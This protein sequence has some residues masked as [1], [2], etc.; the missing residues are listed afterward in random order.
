MNCVNQ[1]T[2]A[3]LRLSFSYEILMSLEIQG[4]EKLTKSFIDLAPEDRFVIK[5]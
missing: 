1:G 4:D 3:G 2:E 5:R